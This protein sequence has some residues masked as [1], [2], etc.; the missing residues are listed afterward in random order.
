M[1]LDLLNVRVLVGD[2][3][4]KVLFVL[5]HV[6]VLH[7]GVFKHE[8]VFELLEEAIIALFETLCMFIVVRKGNTLSH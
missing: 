1:I 3:G 8:L 4:L 5:L 6:S 2:V 7:L